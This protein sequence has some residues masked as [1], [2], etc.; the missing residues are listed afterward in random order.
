MAQWYSSYTLVQRAL[1]ASHSAERL[2]QCD[3]EAE[4]VANLLLCSAT[5]ITSVKANCYPADFVIPAWIKACW[6]TARRPTDGLVGIGSRSKASRTAC[7]VVDKWEGRIFLVT[8]LNSTIAPS[9]FAQ[10]SFDKHLLPLHDH[11][12]QF[13]K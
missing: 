2:L 9:K 7:I 3:L 1:T 11:L 10:C 4:N 6:E 12:S 5:R 13:V 8:N